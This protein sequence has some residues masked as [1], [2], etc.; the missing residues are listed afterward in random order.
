MRVAPLIAAGFV[1]APS[2]MS[3]LIWVAP[4][5]AYARGPTPGYHPW[6]PTPG[7]VR[8]LDLSDP[9]GDGRVWLRDFGVEQPDLSQLDLLRDDDDATPADG[10]A[11]RLGAP[12]RLPEGWVQVGNVVMPAAVAKGD[13]VVDPDVIAAIEDW[14]GNEYPRKHTLY[15][16]FVGGELNVGS[17]NSAEDTSILARQGPYP[18]YT[19]GEQ[20]A[21]SIAQ[22]VENDVAG[23]GIRVAY[24]E[25]PGKIAPYTMEMIGGSWQNVNTDQPAGGVAPGADCGALGQRHIV[26]T[27]AAGS[28]PVNR[29][30]NTAS[31]EA[32][33]AWGLDHTFN[34]SSVM[35]YCANADGVFSGTCDD[36]CESGCQGP[37][38]AGC[39]LTHEAFCG[40]G[41]DQQNE[42]QTLTWL[43]GS[44]E[45]DMVAPTAEIIS[46]ADGELLPEG[47]NVELKALV[48]DD[49]G[50]Y[51]WAWRITRDDEVIFDDVDYERMVD[52]D[53]RPSLNL[54][55]LTTGVWQFTITVQD[56]YEHVTS[57]TVTVS[58]GGVPLPVDSDTG[59]PVASG[60]VGTDAPSGTDGNADG[61][62]GEPPDDCAC[63]SGRAAPA[64]WLVWLP[65]LLASRRRRKF[66]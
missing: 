63:R 27:F 60:A 55:G 62:D 26:Y 31:Q 44:E 59:Q 6:A 18:A 56:Q 12:A 49:Y 53:Y 52:E 46:P 66:R 16:N 36:L 42:V 7:Q 30:A 54:E 11:T 33:H 40:V 64:G 58:V 39:R 19:G 3:I 23:F 34:C 51:G 47:A 61:D 17:D 2:L 25:R 24:H 22:A 9:G 29:V 45:P 57:D 48:G 65:L 41:N 37:N 35:S 50:G 1:V 14:P 21:L 13:A 8:T 32:G 15:L 10:A 20:N 5:H 4:G 38:T 43:F 28:T